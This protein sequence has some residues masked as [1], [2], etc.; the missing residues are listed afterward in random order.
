MRAVLENSEVGTEVGEPVLATDRDGD[1]LEYWLWGTDWASFDVNSRTGQLSSKT[2]LDR[3]I[4]N[5]Y[6]V[7]MS[8][9]DGRGRV[10]GIRVTIIVENVDEP[11]ERPAVPDVKACSHSALVVNW[12]A[13]D[14]QGPEITSYDVRYREAGQA[15]QDAGFHGTGTSL[16]LENLQ[17]ETTYEVQVRA[18][19]AE[20]TSPWSE[21]GQCETIAVPSTLAPAP[22]TEPTDKPS[23]TP[24][25][26]ATAAA[27]D[28]TST[29][30]PT[31]VFR[32]KPTP[33]PTATATATAAP[34]PT[35]TPVPTPVFRAKPTSEPTLPPSPVPTPT[36]EPTPPPIGNPVPTREDTPPPTPT[37]DEGDD[38]FPWWAVL[39]VVLGAIPGAMALVGIR[40]KYGWA[41]FLW[42]ADSPPATVISKVGMAVRAVVRSGGIVIRMTRR[43]S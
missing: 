36:A 10:D 14:N 20:G 16:T 24:E 15:F 30:V 31:P 35:S 7:L 4:K 34:D 42:R 12:S 9:R 38:R 37:T 18:A 41:R 26:T 21:S 29:P 39:G 2:A 43:D 19:N 5:E 6:L 8:V 1:R 27:P 17:S 11:P 40:R 3:E 28:P 23:P 32:A 25:P 33:E 13:P 22:T